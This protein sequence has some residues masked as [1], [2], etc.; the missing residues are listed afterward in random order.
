MKISQK[1]GP[2]DQQ[3]H[4]KPWIAVVTGWPVASNPAIR[5]GEYI[6]DN[7]G[8]ETEVEAMAG[9]VVRWGQKHLQGKRISGHWGIVSE[10][11]SITECTEA[12]ARQAWEQRSSSNPLATI[13]DKDLIAEVRRRGIHF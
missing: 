7:T 11:G 9:D 5:W 13:S 6:G 1:F 10:D 12:A 4:S 8:G 3:I 2:Y